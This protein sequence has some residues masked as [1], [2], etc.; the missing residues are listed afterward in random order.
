MKGSPIEKLWSKYLPHSS[1]EQLIKRAWLYNHD[2][3]LRKLSENDGISNKHHFCGNLTKKYEY[4]TNLRRI[5]GK[6]D[7][8]F[9][10]MNTRRLLVKTSNVNINVNLWR[11]R[12]IYIWSSVRLQTDLK[13]YS[14]KRHAKIVALSFSLFCLKL[15]HQEY[16]F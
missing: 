4:L 11:F 15:E 16:H 8:I 12:C 6:L 3:L 7:V 14:I 1:Y 2:E 9:I 5:Y 13:N 10:Q